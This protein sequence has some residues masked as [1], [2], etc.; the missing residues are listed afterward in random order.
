MVDKT[1]LNVEH[2]LRS[3]EG[4][5]VPSFE[6]T[7]EGHDCS[8]LSVI[9]LGSKKGGLVHQQFGLQEI[10]PTGFFRLFTMAETFVRF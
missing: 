3:F 2:S 1:L 7:L 4:P 10:L 6:G 8:I 5:L 9:D